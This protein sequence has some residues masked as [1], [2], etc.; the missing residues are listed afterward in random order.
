MKHFNKEDSSKRGC[1]FT[2]SAKH[3]DPEGGK[4]EEK[5]EEEKAEVADLRQG[6]H[7][8]VEEGSDALGHLEELQYCI[9]KRTMTYQ[10][11]KQNGGLNALLPLA[12]LRTLMTRM[13]VGLMGMRSDLSSSR[14]MPRIER[15]TITTSN[16]FHLQRGRVRIEGRYLSGLLLR[17]FSLEAGTNGPKRREF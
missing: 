3:F 6:L 11:S 4:D 8:S 14:T 1:V 15:I 13:M 7:H 12:I 16:W 9:R 2:E 10:L 17:L 5:E